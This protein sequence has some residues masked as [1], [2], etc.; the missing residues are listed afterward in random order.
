MRSVRSAGIACDVRRQTRLRRTKRRSADSAFVACGE[1]HPP[2][3][4]GTEHADELRSD[5]VEKKGSEEPQCKDGKA[6]PRDVVE[7]TTGGYAPAALLRGVRDR[8]FD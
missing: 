4:V 1:E 5:V 3:P 8:L 7:D 6:R 2:G